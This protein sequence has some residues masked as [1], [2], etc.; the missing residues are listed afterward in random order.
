MEA[1]NA[2]S[3]DKE[4]E[5]KKLLAQ[6]KHL[7]KELAMHDALSGRNNV[8]YGPFSPE[9]RSQ[10]KARL[11]AYCEGDGPEP[12]MNS[13][14]QIRENYALFRQLY[15]EQAAATKSI[16]VETVCPRCAGGLSMSVETDLAMPPV[17][18][19]DMVG[20]LAEDGGGEGFGVGVAPPGAKPESLTLPNMVAAVKRIGT[21]DVAAAPLPVVPIDSAEASSTAASA[22]EEF[23][24]TAGV[25]THA[26]LL[27]NKRALRESK[28]SARTHATQV[29]AAKRQIDDAKARL[30]R[31][32]G[33]RAAA[34]P[35]GGAAE[36]IGEEEFQL[37]EAL[38]KAKQRYRDAFI[39]LTDE[40]DKSDYVAQTVEN[41]RAQLLT[42]FGAFLKAERPDAAASADALLAA[43][44]AGM[45]E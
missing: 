12:E 14:R 43:V 27:E 44:S 28:A 16:S 41:C 31:L 33:P 2:S 36:V 26:L 8:S 3:H 29:N 24:K 34:S 21:P 6:V 40:T 42:D 30:D 39:R 4:G 5:I 1:G 7:K 13:L 17:E 37:L 15:Q 22:F 19:I 38:R 23:K 45:R 9:A 20:T 18:I 35:A 10:M 11:L 32:R 25:D